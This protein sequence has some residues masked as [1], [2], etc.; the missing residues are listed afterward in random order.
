MNSGNPYVFRSDRVFGNHSEENRKREWSE[1]DA[2]IL[3]FAEDDGFG[4]LRCSG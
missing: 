4:S 1:L 3:R 2:E